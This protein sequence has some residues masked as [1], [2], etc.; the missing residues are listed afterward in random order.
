MR[1]REQIGAGR[2]ASLGVALSFVLAFGFAERAAAQT[3]TITG[4][5]QDAVSQAPIAGAQVSVVGTSLG[6]LA[7]NVGRF[8]IINVPAGEHTVRVDMIGYGSTEMQVTVPAGGAATA[9]FNLR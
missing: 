7:N 3:G 6:V 5:V 8:L 4:A 9:D 2:L 1:L